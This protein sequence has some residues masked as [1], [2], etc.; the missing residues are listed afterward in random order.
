M[1]RDMGLNVPNFDDISRED[2]WN[3]IASDHG[4]PEVTFTRPSDREIMEGH[5]I[6]VEGTPVDTFI[7]QGYGYSLMEDEDDRRDY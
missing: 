6:N 2:A 4:E 3:F 7:A 5:G 1:L